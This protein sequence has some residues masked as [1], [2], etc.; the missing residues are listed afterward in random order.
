MSDRHIVQIFNKNETKIYAT[1]LAIP[2]Y[3]LKATDKTAIT[4][5]E[6]PAG[7][8]HA[9]RAWF[10]PGR[11]WGEEF[12]YPKAKAMQLAKASAAPVLFTPNEVPAEVTETIQPADV[13]V[14]TPV[15]AELKQTPILAATPSG[16]EAPIAQFVTPPPTE[17]Q[18][19]EAPM[20]SR[21]PATA[22]L[23]PLAG[24]LGLLM[25]GGVYLVRSVE[26]HIR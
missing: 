5:H 22:S 19:A 7:E 9:L 8:A 3:R 13:P 14:E 16:T 15:I 11:T 25:L 2:N 23:V 21:L 24:A 26:K 12:V 10:Y 1:I 18:V 6:R 20:A 4:F 17:V